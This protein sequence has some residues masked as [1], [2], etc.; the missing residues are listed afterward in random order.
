MNCDQAF[1]LMTDPV[2]TTSL[3]LN[4]H[5]ERCPRCR[6]MQQTLSPALDWMLA[7]S[8]AP[9][10]AAGASHGASP[11]LSAQ[12]VLVAEEAARSLPKRR[13]GAGSDALRRAVVIAAV[14][15]LGVLFG[16][17]SQEP[18]APQTPALPAGALAACLWDQPQLR[19]QLADGSARGVVVSCV[20]CHVPTTV[21]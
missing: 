13:H 12:A 17:M 16:A 5:L 8:H 20:V 19:A 6:Q 4:R 2:G 9:V 11:F 21:Q 18:A 14:A 7:T 15:V 10:E 1:E 3:A